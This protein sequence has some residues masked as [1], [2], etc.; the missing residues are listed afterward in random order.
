M[1]NCQIRFRYCQKDVVIQCEKN[2]FMREI[3]ARFGTKSWLSVDEFNFLYN[4]D[5]I[6]P[7]IILSQINDKDS[8]ILILVCPKNNNEKENIL[9]K[10]DYIKCA[11]CDNP[12]IITF[13]NDYEINL[14]D[15]KHETKKIKLQD[16]NNTQMINQNGIKC[17]KCNNSRANIYQNNFYY[18]LECDKNFC[19]ICKSLH[20]EHKNIIDFSLK[21]FKCPQHLDKDFI[22]YCFD[23]KKNLCI[24]CLNQHKTH[25]IINFIDLFQ[26]Q[27]QNKE[28]I[29]KI[30]KINELVDSIIDS[31][32]KFKSNLNV[33][34]QINEILNKNFFNMNLNYQ[35]LKSMK[36]LIEMSFLKK[37][38]DQIL[39]S[40]DVNEKFQK[41]MLRYNMMKD[42]NIINFDS[43]DTQIKKALRI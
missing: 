34:L 29:E 30:Q 41:I 21:Y 7:N 25:N 16:F 15:G 10:S 3:I 40:N 28:F 12:A 2:E 18:C 17:S 13:S 6:N 4:G 38:I 26:E 35:N 27:E 37:D 8:E 24:F 31:L 22:S 43:D 19:S 23:C 20:K 1:S 42:N 5:K 9:K 39:N 33:Y 14:S 32:T 11:Q 36:N